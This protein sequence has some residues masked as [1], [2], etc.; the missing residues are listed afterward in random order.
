[1]DIPWNVKFIEVEKRPFYANKI[2]DLFI[3]KIKENLT[4]FAKLLENVTY[5][6]KLIDDCFRFCTLTGVASHFAYLNENYFE[7]FAEIYVYM[8]TTILR[9]EAHVCLIPQGASFLDEGSAFFSY[10]KTRKE[11]ENFNLFKKFAEVDS[12]SAL[13]SNLCFVQYLLNNNNDNGSRFVSDIQCKELAGIIYRKY[14]KY[15]TTEKIEIIK[16]SCIL[17]LGD[18]YEMEED[19]EDEETEEDEENEEEKN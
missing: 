18:D 1:L 3:P 4:K 19:E 9:T 16:R 5:K 15:N 6:K 10:L 13:Y 12:Y 14:K 7:D 2:N 11:E 17:I 8:F